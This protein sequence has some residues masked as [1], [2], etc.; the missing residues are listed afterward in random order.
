MRSTRTERDEP[1]RARVFR[2]DSYRCVY[3]GEEFPGE[4]LTLDHVEPRMRGGDQSEGNLVTACR[5]CNT[6]KASL[7]AWAYLEDR[8]IERANFLR[9]ATSVWPRLSRAIIEAA[10]KKRG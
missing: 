8:P 3:C 5:P 9:L 10:E 2:R 7:P 4:Q 6:Q 1:L